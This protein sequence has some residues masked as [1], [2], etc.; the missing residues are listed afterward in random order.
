[1]EEITVKWFLGMDGP[2]NYEGHFSS[3]RAAAIRAQEGRRYG[4]YVTVKIESGPV[5]Y[6]IWG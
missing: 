5:V 2:Q 3:L 4:Y 6:Q 1:M